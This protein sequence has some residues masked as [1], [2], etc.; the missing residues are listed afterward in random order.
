MALIETIV[1]STL[2]RLSARVLISGGIVATSE[3]SLAADRKK[4]IER[5]VGIVLA[6]LA[7]AQMLRSLP[8]EPLMIGAY[9][10]WAPVTVTTLSLAL[11]I[12][13]PHLSA[14]LLRSLQF[15]AV[16]LTILSTAINPSVFALA[17]LG[18]MTL[19]ALDAHV[20]GPSTMLWAFKKVALFSGILFGALKA[21]HNAKQC[22]L[23]LSVKTAV[24][25]TA[26]GVCFGLLHYTQPEAEPEQS[27]ENAPQDLTVEVAAD[28]ENHYLNSLTG[29]YHEALEEAQRVTLPGYLQRDLTEVEK[30]FLDYEIRRKWSLI[31][32]PKIKGRITLLNNLPDQIEQPDWSNSIRSE[33]LFNCFTASSELALKRLSPGFSGGSQSPL[34]S[35]YLFNSTSLESNL[36]LFLVKVHSKT[37]D[38]AIQETAIAHNWPALNHLLSFGNRVTQFD[39]C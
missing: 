10:A 8:L 4:P 14:Y 28:V 6:T 37:V 7:V 39:S 19:F 11:A 3:N 9:I 38:R 36:D 5:I 18:A 13:A 34:E 25:M 23:S 16:A 24:L 33:W 15:T 22:A 1:S 31:C 30:T 21:M 20:Q 29:V 35:I 12:F 27:T 26:F 2:Y 17:T 32:D